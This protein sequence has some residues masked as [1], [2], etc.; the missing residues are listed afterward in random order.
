MPR[1]GFDSETGGR[2]S[3]FCILPSAFK[4]GG[5]TLFSLFAHVKFALPW[6]QFLGENS[7]LA[8]LPLKKLL[9]EATVLQG[10]AQFVILLFLTSPKRVSSII[11]PA[12]SGVKASVKRFALGRSNRRKRSKIRGPRRSLTPKW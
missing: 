5:Q 3:A 2:T 4:A 7:S 8:S 11:S 9:M 10:V 6:F 12:P 1:M